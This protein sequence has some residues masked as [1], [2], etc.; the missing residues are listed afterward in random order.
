MEGKNKQLSV[1]IA[2]CD[3]HSDLWK[4]FSILWR[5]YWPDCPFEV[6]CATES[7][8]SPESTN[9]L[10]FDRIIPCTKEQ[11][12]GKFIST[13][14]DKVRTPH[15][16]LLCDDYFLADTVDTALILSLLDS[17]Q[18]NRIG[19]LPMIPSAPGRQPLEADSRLV[20]YPKGSAYCIALQAGIWDMRFLTF[21]AHKNFESIWAFER[22]GSFATSESDFIIAGT[23]LSSFPF[24]DVVHKGKWEPYGI[25][26]CQRNRIEIDFSKRPPLSNWK[27]AI[28]YFR[29]AILNL[30]PNI[31][32]KIQN[33]FS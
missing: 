23:K 21:L 6:I 1:V 25:R 9:D 33:L 29:G 30:S 3:K 14:L 5:K 26:L 17:A 20:V 8:V 27:L 12:W 2:S 19:Y 16:I 11:N 7:P 32:T 22:K 4:P 18:Q 31:V 15:I 28:K 13:A 10:C 24:E